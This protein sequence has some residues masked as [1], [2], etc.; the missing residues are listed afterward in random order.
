M[1]GI[2]RLLRITVLILQSASDTHSSE[3]R[4]IAADSD[5]MQEMLLTQTAHS[6]LT[7][8]TEVPHINKETFQKTILI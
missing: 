6:V 2:D 4:D 7:V 1:S 3:Y 8:M 5:S